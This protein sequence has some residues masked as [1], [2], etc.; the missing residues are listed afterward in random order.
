MAT[1]R[2]CTR[3]IS[4][5]AEVKSIQSEP[6]KP[7]NAEYHSALSRFR[8]LNW[9][10]AGRATHAVADSHNAGSGRDKL[11]GDNSVYASM[12]VAEYIESKFVPEYIAAKTSTGRT[13]F[14]SI[15]K[16]VL[17]PRAIRRAFG[18]DTRSTKHVCA[19]LPNWPYMDA[20]ALCDVTPGVVAKII[21]EALDRGYSVQT[22][23]H[24]RN[25]IRTM[26]GHATET[27]LFFGENPTV[28]VTLPRMVRKPAPRLTL[29][30][31]QRILQVAQYPEREIALMATLTRMSVAEICGL[32]WKH[33]NASDL[34]RLIEGDWLEARTIAVRM[35]SCRGEFGPVIARR[36]RDVRLPDLL[37]PVLCGMRAR[38]RFNGSDDF[39]FASRSGSPAS[40]DNLAMRKLKVIGVA[41]GMPWLSWHAFRR[42]HEHLYAELGRQ[43]HTEL[44]ATI[45]GDRPS[46]GIR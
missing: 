22:A 35:Q 4:H 39:V 14:R 23:T 13:H 12:T 46:F 40:Q 31:L 3:A 16:F 45:F 30:Q 18:I 34:R 44:K 20:M 27:N 19:P 1:N 15:L 32:Q 38:T 29:D 37:I 26:F 6:A 21:S 24:I 8:E 41:L 5:L 10:S 42:T 28:S 25:V 17:T 43:L 36:R 33:V 7:Q 11:S 2:I 9:P